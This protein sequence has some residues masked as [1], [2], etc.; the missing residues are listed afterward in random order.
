MTETTTLIQKAAQKPRPSKDDAAALIRQLA[1]RVPED[2]REFD[3]LASLYTHFLPSSPGGLD[4]LTHDSF[5][6]VAAA[7]HV[8]PDQN[9]Y[10]SYVYA[11]GELNVATDGNRIHMVPDD[12]EP[13]YYDPET[14]H[15][16]KGLESIKFPD[17]N[18]YLAPPD[19]KGYL[20]TLRRETI[21]E[22]KALDSLMAEIS[23]EGHDAD[24]SMYICERY[25][26]QAL[27]PGNLENDTAGI[28][29]DNQNQRKLRIDMDAF[30]GSIALIMGA[31]WM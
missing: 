25:L 21:A 5:A 15:Y 11:T 6:W 27:A 20:N 2:S 12:R 19:Y 10:K 26:D 3:N 29:I 30:G 23:I 1:T 24:A 9:D 8:N 16:A 28:C 7:T 14:G 31:Q 4:K 22:L 17:F 18:Q 13:G